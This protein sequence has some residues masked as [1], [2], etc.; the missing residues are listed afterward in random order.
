MSINSYDPAAVHSMVQ[1]LQKL[2]KKIGGTGG[3]EILSIIGS[4]EVRSTDA[5]QSA[6][7]KYVA[8]LSTQSPQDASLDRNSWQRRLGALITLIEEKCQ[9]AKQD[10]MVVYPDDLLDAAYRVVNTN[11]MSGSIDDPYADIA[12]L[13]TRQTLEACIAAGIVVPGPNAPE[14]A[15]WTSDEEKE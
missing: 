14:W 7:Q 9:Q 13:M 1:R 8:S 6:V 15:T 12:K 11:P 10:D 5:D 4:M 3:E 2:A